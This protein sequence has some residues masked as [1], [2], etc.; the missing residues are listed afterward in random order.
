MGMYCIVSAI[1]AGERGQFA[2][3]ADVLGWPPQ[4]GSTESAATATATSV[5]LEKSW[6][7]L[8]YLLTGDVWEG[9]GPLAFLVSGGEQLG[10]DDSPIHWFTPE[11]TRDIQQALAGV[12]DDALWSRF[13]ANEM[14]RQDIYP[15]IWDE[16]EDDLKEEYLEYFHELK[17]LVTAAGEGGQGLLVAI[18]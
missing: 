9:I 7:G 18:G 2:A 14:Q 1:A 6:H 13:D 4:R 11:E 8:H 17:Q 3:D 16:E 15:G 5:S 12:S 10:D